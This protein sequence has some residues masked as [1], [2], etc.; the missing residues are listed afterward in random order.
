MNLSQ[1]LSFIAST[2]NSCCYFVQK[3]LWP[4]SNWHRHK[5]AQAAQEPNRNNWSC[6][7]NFNNFWLVFGRWNKFVQFY[8]KVGIRKNLFG[9][10]IK[11]ALCEPTRLTKTCQLCPVI[12]VLDWI[13]TTCMITFWVEQMLRMCTN[14]KDDFKTNTLAMDVL[15]ILQKEPGSRDVLI[16]FV[17]ERFYWFTLKLLSLSSIFKNCAKCKENIIE[18]WFLFLRR[19]LVVKFW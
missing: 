3:M 6:G 14:T 7:G 19:A 10:R 16:H 17:Y 18:L 9:R 13:H 8:S 15:T 5:K 1:M 2:A 4:M 11:T 12:Y